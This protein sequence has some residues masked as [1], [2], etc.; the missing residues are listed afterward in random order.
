MKHISLRHEQIDQPVPVVCGLNNDADDV[1]L[2]WRQS[3]KN[4][5]WIIRQLLLE[6]ESGVKMVKFSSGQSL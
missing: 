2:V 6:P 4:D 1:I 3:I 5:L